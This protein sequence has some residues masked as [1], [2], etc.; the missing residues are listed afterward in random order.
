DAIATADLV[1]EIAKV[2][3]DLVVQ[4]QELQSKGNLE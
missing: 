1:T 2:Q 3:R 4:L